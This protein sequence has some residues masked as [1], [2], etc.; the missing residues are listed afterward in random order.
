MRDGEDWV[1]DGS[2]LWITNG[3]LASF[4]TVFAKTGKPDEQPPHKV[5]VELAAFGVKEGDKH[6]LPPDRRVKIW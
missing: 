2:K 4:F 1:L 6:Y 3:G 5:K